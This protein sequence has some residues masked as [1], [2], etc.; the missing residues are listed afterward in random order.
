M[1]RR[2]VAHPPG[3]LLV[4][5]AVAGVFLAGCQLLGST[6]LER[7]AD[8]ARV[9]PFVF[10]VDHRDATIADDESLDVYIDP[11]APAEDVERLWCVTLIPAG[12]DDTNT[13]VASPGGSVLI[14]RP[15]SC[16][17][18]GPAPDQ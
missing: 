3:R 16:P 1:N 5:A 2:R 4:A 9:Y 13:L 6:P 11:Y 8:A 17:S 15:S 18:A 14:P 7:A 12:A 10:G